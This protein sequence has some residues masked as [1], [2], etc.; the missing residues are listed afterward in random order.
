MNL[1]APSRGQVRRPRSSGPAL[2]CN[3]T[4]AAES[5]RPRIEQTP[6]QFILMP[7]PTPTRYLADEESQRYQSLDE[8][9]RLLMSAYTRKLNALQ[10]DERFDPRLQTVLAAH[11]H[12][13]G[14]QR[15][16]CFASPSK[17]TWFFR[18]RFAGRFAY[19]ALGHI[20]RPQYLGGQKHV[21]YSGSIERI[22]LGERDDQ[23]G[24]VLL[25]FGPEGL[26]GEPTVLPLASDAD[27]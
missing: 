27:L 26:R 17:K 19:I 8:K 1:A 6:I 22:D 4:D 15:I 25:D 13:R 10:S 23:K 3:R 18:R 20:H 16:R 14:A 9:N 21:R 24:V 12:V 5:A 2:S 11:V 7:Y